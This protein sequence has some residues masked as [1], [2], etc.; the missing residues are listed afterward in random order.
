MSWP[1]WVIL[2]WYALS[3]LVIIAKIGKERKPITPPEA[4]LS[5]IFTGALA[6]LVVIA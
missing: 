6:W 4:A 1:K 5:L 2:S 3:M